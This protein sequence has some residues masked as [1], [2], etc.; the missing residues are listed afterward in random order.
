MSRL[1]RPPNKKTHTKNEIIIKRR[2]SRLHEIKTC[3]LKCTVILSPE[4][5]NQNLRLQSATLS[6]QGSSYDDTRLSSFDTW[7]SFLSEVESYLKICSWHSNFFLKKKQV[8]NKTKKETHKRQ[9]VTLM[10]ANRRLSVPPSCRGR[11]SARARA[12]Q[13]AG[14]HWTGEMRELE[15]T[16]QRWWQ[17]QDVGLKSSWATRWIPSSS[18][19]F[20]PHGQ[21]IWH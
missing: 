19:G 11:P 20:V 13:L 3:V 12:F 5:W 15:H 18:G 17:Q 16:G 9:I 2:H 4:I 14:S 10:S 21:E 6:L 7:V 8:K 1:P